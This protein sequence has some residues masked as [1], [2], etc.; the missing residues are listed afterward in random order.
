MDRFR[1]A[2]N[3]R[4]GCNE[5]VTIPLQL[6]DPFAIMVSSNKCVKCTIVY[7]VLLYYTVVLYYSIK[8][9]IKFLIVKDITDYGCSY[10]NN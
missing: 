8:L 1:Y 2:K 4:E 10:F 9:L 7:L 3:I 6:V 5:D